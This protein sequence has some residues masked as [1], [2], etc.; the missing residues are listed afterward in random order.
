M[1]T[2]FGTRQLEALELAKD[3]VDGCVGRSETDGAEPV[4]HRDGRP[5]ERAREGAERVLDHELGAHLRELRAS[6]HVFAGVV[7][8][9]DDGVAALAER[10]KGCE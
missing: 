1:R 4:R 6:R 8:A 7:G 3:S 5:A 9:H 10:P 2:A